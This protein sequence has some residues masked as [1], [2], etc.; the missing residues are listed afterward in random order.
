MERLRMAVPRMPH[1][2]RREPHSMCFMLALT[3]RF[4]DG[5]FSFTSKHPRTN[6]NCEWKATEE[7]RTQ[8][9]HTCSSLLHTRLSWAGKTQQSK[10]GR[11]VRG[12]KTGAQASCRSRG[13]L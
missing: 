9:S 10:A 8:A 13:V 3:A 6:R 5:L 12:G 1:T 2:T 7:V 11:I 4:S